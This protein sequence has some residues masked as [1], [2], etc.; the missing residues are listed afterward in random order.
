MDPR[1]VVRHDLSHG[2][3]SVRTGVRVSSLEQEVCD[4]VPVWLAKD[5]QGRVCGRAAVLIVAN[6]TGASE[7]LMPWGWN[8]AM[9]ESVRGQVTWLHNTT[10]V[11]HPM[12]G[13]GYALRL[14]RDLVMCGASSHTPDEDPGVR[15]EDHDHNLTRLARLTGLRALAQEVT[16][17]R[18][19]FRLN[20]W[21]KLPLVGPWP[22]VSQRQ[23]HRTDQARM[24]PR[25]EGLYV[26]AGLGGRGL[27]WAP[28][29]SELLSAWITAEPLPLESDLVDALDPARWQVKW[30][31][32]GSP[33]KSNR[34][35]A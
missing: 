15:Q 7:L 12:A 20:T 6:G 35:H 14:S 17:G 16:G 28:L 33:G 27:T 5:D 23:T 11:S 1:E 18:T 24:W 26:M 8:A 13:D 32:N 19:A 29:L 4:D 25:W 2:T 21:D 9:T 34:T 10:A 30:A 22:D 3:I 31:R